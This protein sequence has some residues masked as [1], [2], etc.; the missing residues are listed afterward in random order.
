MES[1]QTQKESPQENVDELARLK[2]ELADSER[3]LA[4]L[5]NLLDSQKIMDAYNKAQGQEK[6]ALR[7]S[8]EVAAPRCITLITNIRT[9]G[10]SL[11]TQGV[12][13]QIKYIETEIQKLKTNIMKL[14]TPSTPR[15]SPRKAPAASQ[16]FIFPPLSTAD[17]PQRRRS[18]A[19]SIH[20]T[21]TPKPN[22]M[23]RR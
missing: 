4:L 8:A 2:K 13:H 10:F 18:G 5:K 7:Q 12:P 17:S 19:F 9:S 20:D 3:L 21:N 6:I 11:N 15:R 22:R 23:H 14:E 16:L 1:R